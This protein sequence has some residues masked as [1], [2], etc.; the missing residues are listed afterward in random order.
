MPRSFEDCGVK[1]EAEGF[2]GQ[3]RNLKS[4]IPSHKAQKST[5][6][7]PQELKAE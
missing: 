6:P 4:K 1:D 3:G 2:V 7:S 5:Y